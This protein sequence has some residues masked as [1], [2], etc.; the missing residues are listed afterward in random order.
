MTAWSCDPRAV[1]PDLAPQARPPEFPRDQKQ[2]RGQ[3]RRA[4][5]GP[6]LSRTSAVPS[7]PISLHTPP[8][9]GFPLSQ[10]RQKRV[11]A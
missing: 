4:E 2:D 7:T 10:E 6:K 1:V 8:L 3:G 9:T 5:K 11:S